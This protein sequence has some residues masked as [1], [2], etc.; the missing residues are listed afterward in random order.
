MAPEP[1][2]CSDRPQN[3]WRT[4]SD[5][6]PP[7]QHIA[8]TGT[9][10]P[11]RIFERFASLCKLVNT[12]GAELLGTGCGGADLLFPSAQVLRSAG[13]TASNSP[14]LRLWLWDRSGAATATKRASAA[15]YGDGGGQFWK[16]WSEAGELL[17]SLCRWVR[18]AHWLIATPTV[19][20]YHRNQQPSTHR[21]RNLQRCA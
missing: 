1:D 19:V 3:Q 6:L 10:D 11:A 16:W 17:P 7:G 5:Y 18:L 20:G 4:D 14:D 8:S 13:H 21:H 2:W 12:V 9:L 15:D